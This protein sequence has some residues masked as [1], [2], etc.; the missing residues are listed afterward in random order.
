MP[1]PSGT[2][3]ET[4]LK[5]LAIVY[6]NDLAG[7]PSY[8]YN[9][10]GLLKQKFYLYMSEGDLRNVYHHLKELT[11]LGLVEKGNYQPVRGAPMRQPYSMT[12]KGRDLMRKFGKYLNVLTNPET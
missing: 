8:G 4:K 5:I 2:I 7:I 11:S 6:H 1:R 9:I 12:E 3:G 10:W